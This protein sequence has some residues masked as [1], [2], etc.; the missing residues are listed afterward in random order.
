MRQITGRCT[1][2]YLASNRLAWRMILKRY[3]FYV[4]ENYCYGI[5]RPIQR[6]LKARGDE[7]A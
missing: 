1:F 3:L 7:V 4:E 6:V 2:L 5:L